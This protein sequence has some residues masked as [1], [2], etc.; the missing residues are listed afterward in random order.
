MCH[1]ANWSLLSFLSWVCGVVAHVRLQALG[2]VG[3]PSLVLRF[4]ALSHIAICADGT[5]PCD[6]SHVM[7]CSVCKQVRPRPGCQLLPRC[8]CSVQVDIVNHSVN[9]QRV[10]QG[11]CGVLEGFL[12]FPMV[13]DY[14]II[15]LAMQMEG[16]PFATAAP[17]ARAFP[18]TRALAEHG[19]QHTARGQRPHALRA[20]HQRWATYVLWA[21]AAL[22]H[23]C[24]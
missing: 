11:H 8:T 13:A 9:L 12:A 19:G 17:L 4:G 24:S 5:Q 2:A 16:S 3:S 7:H 21:L 14:L 15:P 10:M 20:K 6:R 18:Y 22:A 1:L 23:A